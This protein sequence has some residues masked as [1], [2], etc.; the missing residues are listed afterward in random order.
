[1]PILITSPKPRSD[2]V[3]VDL[4]VGTWKWLR[5]F[6]RTKGS[7]FGRDLRHVHKSRKEKDVAALKEL[8]G[9]GLLAVADIDPAAPLSSAE[10]IEFRRCYVLT[11]AG[12]AAAE[13][14]EFD[15]DP[16]RRRGKAA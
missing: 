13:Y 6:A 11:E 9:L 10:P 7:A 16:A 8:V 5:Y 3:K 15:R 12:R 1:V 2:P 14:G 4:T